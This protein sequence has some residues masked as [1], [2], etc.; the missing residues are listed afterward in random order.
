VEKAL[1]DAEQDSPV[2]DCGDYHLRADD[3]DVVRVQ[4]ATKA[5]MMALRRAMAITD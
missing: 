1:V 3:P 4:A 5:L 2:H